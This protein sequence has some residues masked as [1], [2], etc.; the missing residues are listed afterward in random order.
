MLKKAVQK[1]VNAFTTHRSE[2]DWLLWEIDSPHRE[3]PRVPWACLIT[4]RELA[5][6][7]KIQRDPRVFPR[8]C[9]P[10][11]PK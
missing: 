7:R 4:Y 10:V 2:I 1:Y 6:C 11:A 5:C 8:P 9:I 3:A